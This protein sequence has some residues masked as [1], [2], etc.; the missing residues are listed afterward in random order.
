MYT[1]NERF[2][3]NDWHTMRNKYNI[4]KLMVRTIDKIVQMI[5]FEKYTDLLYVLILC[6]ITK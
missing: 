1:V 6:I 2:R 4:Y 3:E 5:Y